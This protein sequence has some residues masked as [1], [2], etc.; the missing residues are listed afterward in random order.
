MRWASDPPTVFALL[1]LAACAGRS[2]GDEGSGFLDDYS[3]L[4]KGRGDE[5][6]LLYIDPEASFAS[7][8]RII[9]DPVTV[10]TA[11]EPSEEL[12]EL[13]DHLDAALREQLAR[14]F[15]LVE[16]SSPGTLRLRAAIT[17]WTVSGISAEAEIL[18]AATDRRLVAAVDARRSA[19]DAD[20]S[21][22]SRVRPG[23]L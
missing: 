1:A 14:E 15:A 19:G 20:R 21:A 5:A 8:D 7:Y 18:D 2:V 3:A 22:R 16:D 4:E 11:G 17:G 23:D 6:Q 9:V 10:W 13:A 12:R